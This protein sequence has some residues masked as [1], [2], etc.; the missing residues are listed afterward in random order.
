MENDMFEHYKFEQYLAMKPN[1]TGDGFKSW[2]IPWS[3]GN[4]NAAIIE[5]TERYPLEED[6]MAVNLV[7]EMT[8]WTL[9]GQTIFESGG[10]R[11]Y[12]SKHALIR[13]RPNEPYLWEPMRR[14]LLLNISAPAWVDEQHKKVRRR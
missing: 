9:E 12:F 14:V 3:A 10:V 4:I 5:L 11:E 1:R 7:S 2:D 8:V 6:F 13:V